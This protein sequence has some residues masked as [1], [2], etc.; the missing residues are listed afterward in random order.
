MCARRF[1][2]RKLFSNR[3]GGGGGLRL[4]EV[5]AKREIIQPRCVSN[6]GKRVNTDSLAVIRFVGKG[7]KERK[8]EARGEGKEE[9]GFEVQIR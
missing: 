6:L 3:G 4:V 8:K 2:A 1:A 9:A 5:G 7:E